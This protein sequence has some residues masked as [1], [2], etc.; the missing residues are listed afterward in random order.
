MLEAARNREIEVP[1]VRYNKQDKHVTSAEVTKAVRV[2]NPVKFTEQLNKLSAKDGYVNTGVFANGASWQYRTEKLAF[3]FILA[4]AKDLGFG[5]EALKSIEKDY[6]MKDVVRQ[7][8]LGKDVT[9]N[10]QLVNQLQEIVDKMVFVPDTKFPE[11]NA[12]KVTTADV[13]YLKNIYASAARQ[14][15]VVKVLAGKNM[16]TYVFNAVHQIVTGKPYEIDSRDIKDANN[17]A[18]RVAGAKREAVAVS[19]ERVKAEKAA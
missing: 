17:H 13:N 15:G 1:A 6:R 16:P 11:K 9:T 7:Q 10:T 14:C 8:N 19:A 5:K 18:Y 2:V 12:I 3:H 4:V